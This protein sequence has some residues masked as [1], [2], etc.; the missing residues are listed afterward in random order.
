MFSSVHSF[1]FTVMEWF[2]VGECRSGG[3]GQTVSV[4]D[5]EVV[6][7]MKSLMLFPLCKTQSNDTY[8]KHYKV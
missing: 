5:S 7:E 1:N 2:A 8:V 4:A 3:R 6:E